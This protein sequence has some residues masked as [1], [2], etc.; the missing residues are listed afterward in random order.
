MPPVVDAAWVA[1]HLGEEGLLLADVRGA[2][3]SHP[4]SLPGS[5]PLVLGSPAPV[6]D[7]AVL[8]ETAARS[9]CACG[10]TA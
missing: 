1:E 8:E 9:G 4:R 5:I 10:A 3:R 2:E 6:T 7:R